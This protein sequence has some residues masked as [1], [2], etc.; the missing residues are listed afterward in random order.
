MKQQIASIVSEGGCRSRAPGQAC[1]RWS[2]IAMATALLLAGGVERAR[3]DWSESFDAGFSQAWNFAATDDIGDPPATGASTFAVVEA[4]VDDHLLISHTTTGV[5]DGGGG[6][7]DGF[8]WVDESFSD[9]AVNAE[10]NAFPASGQ[11]S[12]L[13]VLAR[14]NPSMGAVYAAGIDFDASI[15]AIGRSDDFADFF[16]TLAFDPGVAIDPGEPYRVQFFLLGSTLVARLL[17]GTTG[18]LLSTLVAVDGLYASGF[19]G[20]LVETAYDGF[21]NPIAPI[22]GTF[23]DVSA[24][25]EPS[26]GALLASGLLGL[27]ALSRLSRRAA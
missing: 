12:L 11:Q 9:V 25:P 15:F 24:V 23:D 19:A 27:G 4:G 20:V 7:T 8:G 22:V 6:A 18:E 13:G 5:R 10:I 17:D 3:A 14:G 21:D 16:T 26:A 2:P 1:R